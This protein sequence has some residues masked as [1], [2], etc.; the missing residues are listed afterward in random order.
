MQTLSPLSSW[1]HPGPSEW[2]RDSAGILV[3]IQWFGL[4]VGFLLANVPGREPD[5]QI[6]LNLLLSVGL[7]Y[8]CVDSFYYFRGDVFV[9]SRFPLIVSFLETI[10]ITL[11]CRYDIGLNSLYR[12][13]YLLSL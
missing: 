1:I 3:K 10:F 12:F 9:L 6:L 5:S 11:L 8:A 13:Y 7:V 2:Q 4:L